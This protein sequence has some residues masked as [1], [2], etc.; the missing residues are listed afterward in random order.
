MAIKRGMTVVGVFTD[1][2]V[3]AD[4][5]RKRQ[6]PAGAVAVEPCHRLYRGRRRAG[7][8]RR[9]A[10]AALAVR[11]PRHMPHVCEAVMR[12]AVAARGGHGHDSSAGGP[13][14][15]VVT[16]CWADGCASPAVQLPAARPAVST[17]MPVAAAGSRAV[18]VQALGNRRTE[19]CAAV[20]RP[21]W[22][23]FQQTSQLAASVIT[24]SVA[25]LVS[26]GMLRAPPVER[27][28]WTLRM[29]GACHPR[30]V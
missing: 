25:W 7:V 19:V 22:V 4:Q 17:V 6:Q 12:S 20:A 1:G 27:C 28:R 26:A 30:S 23:G 10:L 21:R 5:L 8:R 9:S 13:S 29:A 11:V 24:G 2:F 14:R 3:E 15:P 18:A 16:V